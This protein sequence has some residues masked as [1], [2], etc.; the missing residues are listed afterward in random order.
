V[1]ALVIV[2]AGDH[3]RVMADVARSL[4]RELTGFVEPGRRPEGGSGTVAGLPI[5]GFLD[6]SVSSVPELA[7]EV[8]Y[9]VAIGSNR[10]RERVFG[11]CAELGWRATSLVHH[12]G[13]LLGGADVRAGAQVCA[14]SIIGLDATVGMNAIV[15][16]AAGID[17]DCRIG[18]H[19]F[20]GPGV[21]LAGRVNVETGA[22]VGIGAVVRE[23][24]TIGAWA[25]VAAGA[26]VV[27]DVAAGV[28]VA[29]V[30]ARPMERPVPEEENG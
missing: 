5:L 21:R 2:G 25:Y 26:V 18:D 8:E 14:A 19:A 29:G 17:H 12:S 16:T 15:N 27:H 1:S 4:G 22:H 30:P 24:C 13:L 3:G 28:R 23:G 9:V 20:I 11:R 6:D 7:G 10:E